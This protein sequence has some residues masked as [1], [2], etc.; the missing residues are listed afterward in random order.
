ML[1]TVYGALVLVLITN[2]HVQLTHH[3][4]ALSIPHDFVI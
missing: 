4:G 1:L 2:V 3:G